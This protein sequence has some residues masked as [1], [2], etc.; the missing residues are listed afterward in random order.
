MPGFIITVTSNNKYWYLLGA[1]LFLLGGIAL[2][3]AG[4]VTLGTAAGVAGII[5]SVA[6]AVFLIDAIMNL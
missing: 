6:S 2:A 3:I 5:I 4:F 1:I